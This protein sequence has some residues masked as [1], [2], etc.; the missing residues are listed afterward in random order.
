MAQA[1]ATARLDRKEVKQIQTRV[2]G[3]R[4]SQSKKEPQPTLTQM[5]GG[6]TDGDEDKSDDALSA[7][8]DDQSCNGDT[9]SAD[10][11]SQADPHDS[12]WND[13]SVHATHQFIGSMSQFNEAT[14]RFRDKQMHST[15]AWTKATSNVI[16]NEVASQSCE[17]EEGIDAL[18]ELFDLSPKKTP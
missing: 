2:F 15:A 8:E 16:K 14:T 11:S 4:S 18:V 12:F 7:K 9:S 1:F 3:K 17:E 13:E 10:E 6:G 5:F